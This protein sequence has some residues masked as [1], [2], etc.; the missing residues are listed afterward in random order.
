M[1]EKIKE[2]KRKVG[3]PIGNKFAVNCGRPKSEIDWKR[4]DELLMADCSGSAIA[5]TLGIS[6]FT[7]YDRCL[8]DKGIPFASYSQQM[9][10]KGESLLKEVQ[11]LKAMSG[12]NTLLIWLGKVRLKQKEHQDEVIA[13]EVEL[14][15]DQLMRQMEKDKQKPLNDIDNRSPIPETT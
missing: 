14:K 2:K 8:I 3:A 9:N 6:R 13:K 7:L 11:Y 5:D 15:F 12:E 1:T 4:V 10:I